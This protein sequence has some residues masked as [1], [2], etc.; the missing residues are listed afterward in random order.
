MGREQLIEEF[1][2]RLAEETVIVHRVRDY[3]EAREKLAVVAV[4]EGLKKVMATT[5]D[6]V[7]SLTCRPGGRRITSR[8]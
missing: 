2:K 4:E 1:S 6:V 8:S 7:S 5:D 3:Q